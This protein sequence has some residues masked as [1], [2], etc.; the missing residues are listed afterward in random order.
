MGEELIPDGLRK[1]TEKVYDVLVPGVGKNETYVFT[2]SGGLNGDPWVHGF[3]A[4][5]EDVNVKVSAKGNISVTPEATHCTLAYKPQRPS[6]NTVD[7]NGMWTALQC[8]HVFECLYNLNGSSEEYDGGRFY[9]NPHF[10]VDMYVPGGRCDTVADTL[11]LC[12]VWGYLHSLPAEDNQKTVV[13]T[14]TAFQELSPAG[15]EIPVAMSNV[16]GATVLAGFEMLT[17]ELQDRGVF[18]RNKTL[19]DMFGFEFKGL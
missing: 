8:T 6:R 15:T 13:I 12:L 16:E 4:G 19:N 10:G 3:H 7:I 1:L 9:D 18:T 14:M 11:F 17:R 2:V 5:E